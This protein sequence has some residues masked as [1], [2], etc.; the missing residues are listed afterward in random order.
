MRGSLEDRFWAKVDRSRVD[1]ACWIWTAGTHNGYGIISKSQQ[2]RNYFAHRLSWELMR[3][4]IPN[5]LQIDHLCR[6][7]E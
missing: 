3:G 4:P 5:G 6:V 7:R 1:Q 2:Q